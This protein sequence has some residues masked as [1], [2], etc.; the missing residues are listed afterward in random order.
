M[1]DEA[2]PF[3]LKERT[4]LAV[5][6][7]PQGRSLRVRPGR[8]CL[9]GLPMVQTGRLPR[10]ILHGALAPA[11]RVGSPPPA[12]LLPFGHLAAVCLGS[13]HSPRLAVFNTP[14][15]IAARPP[16]SPYFQQTRDT[17]ELRSGRW[18]KVL[19]SQSQAPAFDMEG[20]I[21]GWVEVAKAV[22]FPG[23]IKRHALP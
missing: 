21:S 20:W 23:E 15:D 5:G 22:R 6:S 11:Q 19:A 8:A 7:G 1:M 17:L 2:P 3:D 14:T 4:K 16:E 10:L 18:L 13:R 9:T 12:I